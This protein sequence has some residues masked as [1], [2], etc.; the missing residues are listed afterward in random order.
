MRILHAIHDFLPRHRAG[1]EIYALELARE[2]AARHHVSVLCAEYDPSRRHGRVTWRVQDGL[3]VIEIV[4]N[5]I[6]AS[7]EET[8]RSPLITD[9]IAHVLGAVQ[10]DIIHVHNLLNLSFD[11]PAL[12]HRRGIPVVATLHDYS[13][14][15]PSGGQRIHRADEYV[16]AT[17]DTE[18]CV[19]CFR[20]SPQQAQIAFGNLITFARAP[21]LMHRAGA[22]VLGRLPWLARP[23]ARAIRGLPAFGLTRTDIDKRLT[24]ARRV[25][26]QVDLF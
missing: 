3:P 15:C 8:Y 25:F 16:C 11:L 7:F 20:E 1:S 9:R 17:I 10:P 12:A 23:M 21:R 5:W 18:R 4:N 22:A 24:A 19:R 2:Q 13:M 6:C 14:V 26:E